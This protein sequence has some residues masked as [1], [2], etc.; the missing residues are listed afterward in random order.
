M[1]PFLKPRQMT[2]IIMKRQPD[3]EIKDD[4]HSE[5]DREGLKLAASSII[6]AIESKDA[7]AL[8]SALKEAFE[9]CDSGP[10]AEGP[11]EEV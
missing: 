4:G 9:I 5:Y 1:L 11:H 3:G 10:H 6:R 7:E 2:A 8:A